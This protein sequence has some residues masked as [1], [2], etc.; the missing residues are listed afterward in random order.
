MRK[1]TIL[2]TGGS[3]FLGRNLANHFKNK[4]K[5]ILGARNNKLNFQAA[6]ETGC[7]M[8]PLDITNIESVRDCVIKY[9]P[10]IIIHAAATKF[11]DLS[12][13][14]PMECVDINVVGSQNV[15]R[16]AIDEC[17]ETVIGISTDKA[18]P[19][20]RNTYGLSKAM[21][22]KVFCNSSTPHTNF[23]CVRYGNVVWSTGSMLPIFKQ[24]IMDSGKVV[25][26]G[27]DMRRFFFTVD[28][29][30]QLIDTALNNIETIKGKIL[31]RYMKAA[32][33]RDILDTI[34]K[35]KGGTW[36]TGDGRPGE[37]VDEYLIGEIELP[38]TEQVEFNNIPHYIISQN[39]KVDNPLPKILSSENTEKLTEKELLDIINLEWHDDK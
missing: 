7:E 26:T 20:V 30:V 12:E 18:A 9:A 3:G 37:R 24:M 31:S 32:M 16:V 22:E 28:D 4:Y 27:P 34:V 14:F 39:Q 13:K 23:A 11:V 8:T 10:E 6:S 19:P 36:E 1:K 21:M 35:Y 25:S 29:A 5:V 15:A 2:I 17:V 33:V 38:F